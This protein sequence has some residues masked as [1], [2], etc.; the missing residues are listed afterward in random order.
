MIID[1]N[2]D[3][4]IK[5]PGNLPTLPTQ[6]NANARK[7][8][9]F[10]HTEKAVALVADFEKK[11]NF[12][13]S[14]MTSW[15]GNSVTAFVSADVIKRLQADPLVKQISQN[16]RVISSAATP[17]PWTE[18]NLPTG[19]VISWGRN[20]VKGKVASVNTGRKIYIIDGGVAL[21]DD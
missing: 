11:F 19:E 8:S 21:H 7:N 20:A 10:F 13:R 18:T 4:H 16:Q 9:E 3:A 6:A 14:G 12:Q 15:A 1:F 5:Y 2:D 17:P